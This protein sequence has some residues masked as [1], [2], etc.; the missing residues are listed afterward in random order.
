MLTPWRFGNDH[1]PVR[2][3]YSGLWCIWLFAARRS[4]NKGYEFW[5]WFNEVGL[6]T[7][8]LFMVNSYIWESRLLWR[9]LCAWL[10][11]NTIIHLNYAI[12]VP[13]I[14]IM[15]LKAN[16]SCGSACPPC[17]QH[18]I[19]IKDYDRYTWYNSR[20]CSVLTKPT[21]VYFHFMIYCIY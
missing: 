13:C 9:L 11:D 3:A 2:Y 10:W 5:Q 12:T 15:L 4:N 7:R 19:V 17:K 14:W 20:A 1:I 8:V 16:R 18:H 21:R 6:I